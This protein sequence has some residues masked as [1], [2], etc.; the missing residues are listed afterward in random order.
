MPRSL[1]GR[2]VV[3]VLL[4]ILAAWLAVGLTLTVVL[5]SLH[6]DATKSSLADIG[7]T[8]VVRFRNAA[9]DT[10]LR[11]LVAEVRDSVAGG[12]ISVQIVRA[13]GSYVDLGSA[14]GSAT[15]AEPLVIPPRAT[16]GATITGS[17]PFTDNQTH[18][19]A[20]TVLRAPGAAGP[21][22][23]VLSL[24]DR[25]RAA[26]FGDLVPTLPLVLLVS[27]IVGIP[28]V[29]V[30]SRSVG[31]PLRRLADATADLP[32]R[33]G[34]DPLPLEG[35]REVK[36]LTARFNAMAAELAEARQRETDLLEDLRH[37][38]RTPLT[39]ISGFAAA[40]ADGTATGPEAVRAA[41]TIGEEAT[42][43]EH[44]V[45]ELGAV[46]RIRHGAEGLRP[47]ALDAGEVVRASSERFASAAEAAGIALTVAAGIA[48]PAV[49][50]DQPGEFARVRGRSW[51]GG[52]DHGQRDRQC[53]R[54]HTIRWAHL[55]L[56]G[57]RTFDPPRAVAHHRPGRHRR[58]PRLPAGHRSARLRAL[59]P[60]RP[61]ADRTWQ[62]PR[63]G[64]RRGA[65]RRSRRH[66][67]RGERRPARGAPERGPAQASACGLSQ[68]P[69]G[70]S[71]D[72]RDASCGPWRLVEHAHWTVPLGRPNSNP[73]RHGR[74][75]DHD[76]DHLDQR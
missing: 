11:G 12:A 28:L 76:P 13:D 51:R 29:L 57:C 60:W 14:G 69:A 21:R 61:R 37:D 47:E 15:P 45:D 54:G 56:G 25:S 68:G 18:L 70:P 24:P 52:A 66:R 41:R 22:A 2:I 26:A 44:L 72:L 5:G 48:T 71:A 16:R 17:A 55:A 64:D 8:L 62:R 42:R 39:V 49:A 9:L 33:S 6:A 53:D 46:E 19:Y 10:D 27:A 30:L 40:L 36:E 59:L 73:G 74:D 65:G 23:I 43:L 3:V 20:A 1:T 35:P 63:T 50:A 58:R 31:G 34:R 32:V 4:P 67:P 7:Q 38:L 75:H